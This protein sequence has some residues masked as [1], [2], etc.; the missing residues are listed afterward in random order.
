MCAVGWDCPTRRVNYIYST[1]FLFVKHRMTSGRGSYWLLVTRYSCFT[2]RQG[3]G[4]QAPPPVARGAPPPAR[5][6]PTKNCIF[7][8]PGIGHP[9]IEG[10]FIPQRYEPSS[11]PLEGWR[12]ADGGGREYG[13]QML[14]TYNSSPRR[15]SGSIVFPWV[16]EIMGHVC[17]FPLL[18]IIVIS[19]DPGL[20]RDDEKRRDLV[21]ILLSFQCQTA[22]NKHK[23]VCGVDKAG[24][25]RVVCALAI[26]P[27]CHREGVK[28]PWRS[29]K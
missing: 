4:W 1:H 20:R 13:M 12:L 26:T 23:C 6:P 28:R 2:L 15:R 10:N 19:M 17:T 11:P 5:N 8:G 27:L 3:F 29:S 25:T 7:A 14:V 16:F 9:S 21:L 22:P 24:M 18:R